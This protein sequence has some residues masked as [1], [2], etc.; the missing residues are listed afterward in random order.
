MFFMS[1][2]DRYLNLID[3]NLSIALLEF[4]KVTLKPDLQYLI[5]LSFCK[6][7]RILDLIDIVNNDSSTS[8]AR[9]LLEP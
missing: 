4:V 3:N 8:M 6:N 2:K 1:P 5:L 9:T 7:Y